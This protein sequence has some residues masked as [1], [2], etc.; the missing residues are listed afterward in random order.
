MNPQG[1]RQQTLVIT[2]DFPPRPGGIQTFIYELVR[3]F[4]PT[5]VTV[6]TSS[7]EGAQEFDAQQPF[8]IIRVKS[9]VLLP[10]RSVRER[11]RNIVVSKNIDS[12]IYGAAAPLALMSSEMR[13]LGVRHQVGITHGHEA[14]WSITPITRQLLAKIGRGVDTLTY[15]GS[16]TKGKIGAVLDQ[17]TR[18]A[19]RQLTPGVDTEQFH[20]RNRTFG[21]TLR[22]SVG[23][24][25]RPTIVCVSRLMERK[26]QDTLLKA[27]PRVLEEIPNAALIVVGSGPFEST[28]RKL[29]GKL[30]L[31]TNVHFTGK[32]PFTELANWYSA[33]D[34]FAMPCRTRNGGWDVEGLG[35]VFLEASATGLAVLAGDSG[36]APDA[37]IE[38]KTGVVVDGTDVAA[39]SDALTRL[40][41]NPQAAAAMGEAGRRWVESS[42]TW[43]R[44]FN[45]LELLL[46]GHDPDF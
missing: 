23:F 41:A 24:A 8:E 9:S 3:R 30:N 28:L 40:L 17:P 13:S 32:V 10:T 27:L 46:A 14:G 5:T 6:L 25:G 43:E 22:E 31:E 20:P 12:I 7:W 18:D 26:G 29:V 16:Y 2:N 45:R 33:G 36:G 38:G 11:A 44:S 1:V 15:L 42:W 37:V 39:V 19:M 21:D 35:I 4:D 34:I